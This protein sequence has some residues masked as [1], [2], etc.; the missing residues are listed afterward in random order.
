[1]PVRLTLPFGRPICPLFLA[2]LVL[3]VVV[4]RQAEAQKKTGET[5]GADTK[6]SVSKSKRPRDFAPTGVAEYQSPNFFVVTDLSPDETKDLLKRLE[7]MLGLIE[8]Y[9]DHKLRAPIS[10]YV[11]KDLKAWPQNVLARFEG[12]GL[13][14]IRDG[15][16]VTMGRSQISRST[17]E[18]V[19]SAATVYAVAD[20][21]TPQH[22]AVHAYCQL[23][24]GRVGPTWYAEGMAEIGQYWTEKGLGVHCHD[25]VLKYLQRSEPKELIE[26]VDTTDQ[27][28]DSWENYAWRWVLCH[29]LANNPNYAPR[30]KPLGLGMLKGQDVSFESVYGSM[31]KEIQFEYSFFL[32]HIDQGFRADLCAWDWS[33]KFAA[34][35][36]P[37]PMTVKIDAMRGWQPSRAIVSADEEYDFSVSG[38]WKTTTSG[39]P[40]NADGATDGNGKLEGV[41]FDDY[42]LSEPFEL[43]TYGTFKAPKSGNLMLRCRDKWNELADNNGK[44]QVKLKQTGK[45]NPLPK[46]EKITAPVDSNPKSPKTKSPTK[47]SEPSAKPAE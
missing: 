38:T 3:G 27:T 29:M 8:K 13:Q 36:G 6:S 9:Y 43:G 12:A 26:I 22:E 46:P 10:M 20:R 42:T 40:V 32:Q 33:S 28:G 34:C 2:L 14:S 19:N 23:S 7:N 31:A 30:F 41:I 47:S 44:L 24:F 17:G 35:K 45:G 18:I 15:A 16:G 37:V 25:V 4:P 5:K 1:M 11:V 21:G 39:T